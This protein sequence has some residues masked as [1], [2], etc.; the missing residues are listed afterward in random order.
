[1]KLLFSIFIRTI[2]LCTFALVKIVLSEPGTIAVED[3]VN[4]LNSKDTDRL[5]A[6][7]PPQ[8]CGNMY[9][10]K[11][12]RRTRCNAHQWKSMSRNW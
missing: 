9:Q 6:K 8:V 7:A 12:P 11:D 3:L 10:S 4:L 5:D 1:M 2:V